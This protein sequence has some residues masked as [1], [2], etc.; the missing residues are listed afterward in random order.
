MSVIYGGEVSTHVKV[1]SG[2][3]Q[4]SILGPLL[5]IIDTNDLQHCISPGT[6][7][8]MY[9]DDTAIFRPVIN[10]VDAYA[11]QSV[12]NNIISW[13][14]KNGIILN[15]SKCALLPISRR[16]QNVFLYD[17]NILDEHVSITRDHKYLGI[18]IQSDLKWQTHII[19]I[20]SKATQTLGFIKRTCGHSKLSY[21]LYL[22]LCRP[23]IEYA[24]PVWNH[25]TKCNINR[26]EGVQRDFTRFFFRQNS[27]NHDLADYL[28]YS[29][30]LTLLNPTSLESRR[31]VELMFL[32]SN[33]L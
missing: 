20:C 11:L 23:I 13:S 26:I 27:I 29:Q 1:T 2:I 6:S 17:Y 19:T 18:T 5:F 32:L 12:L 3:P 21:Q 33:I 10:Q 4:G 22:A 7:M 9:A 25:P 28:N 15:P 14:N 31:V 30:R 8:Y 16:R 24:S